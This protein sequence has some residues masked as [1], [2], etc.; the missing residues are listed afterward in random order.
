[1]HMRIRTRSQNLAPLLFAAAVIGLA[2]LAG[3]ASAGTV[4]IPIV[5]PSFE[6]DQVGGGG[7]SGVAGWTTV[8]AGFGTFNPSKNFYKPYADGGY[9]GNIIAFSNGGT[10]RQGTGRVFDPRHGYELR[11][12]VGHRDDGDPTIFGGFA[13]RLVAGGET[14]AEVSAPASASSSHYPAGRFTEVVVAY[15]FDPLAPTPA[16]G[17]VVVELQGY[18]QQTNYD[19]VRLSVTPVPEPLAASAAGGLA[20][21]ALGR[22]R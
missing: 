9:D 13:A 22:R 10:I 19:L 15:E 8:V 12:L 20:L 2:G 4:S 5:N 11:L 3:P 17:E 6:A 16:A 1:M 14:F 7:V 21:L 18:A